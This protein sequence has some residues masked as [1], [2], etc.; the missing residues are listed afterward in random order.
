MKFH[1]KMTIT[2]MKEFT[3][4]AEHLKDA[5]EMAEHQLLKEIDLNTLEVAYIGLNMDDPTIREYNRKWCE[6]KVKEY[7]EKQ[8]ENKQS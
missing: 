5:R 2:L 7:L 1:L 8:N 4:E 3:I 6:K